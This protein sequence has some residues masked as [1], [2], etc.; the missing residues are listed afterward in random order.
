MRAS[1]ILVRA[2]IEGAELVGVDPAA[3]RREAGLNEGLNDPYAWLPGER[4]D[5]LLCAAVRLSQRPD[6]GLN[7]GAYS[8]MHKLEMLPLWVSN[9]PALRDG[10]RAVERVHQLLFD[11]LPFLFEEQGAECVWTIDAGEL[12]PPAARVVRDSH[13]VGVMRLLRH[14]EVGRAY[15]PIRACFEHDDGGYRA[16][17]GRHFEELAFSQPR[18]ELRF[19]ALEL[20]RTHDNY[21]QE[22][23]GLLQRQI[24]A[25]RVRM[26]ASLPYSDRLKNQLRET[27]P[28]IPDMGEVARALEMSERSLRRRLAD[29]GTTYSQLIEQCQAELAAELLGR[30]GVSVKE[31]AFELGFDT[32]SG[33]YRAFRRWTGR[34]PAK[35][36]DRPSS[37]EAEVFGE[38]ALDVAL[39]EGGD[40]EG[41]V[42]DDPGRDE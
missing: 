38:D 40:G 12:S 16:A 28:R 39:G 27:L 1:T 34:S 3:L 21:N 25:L 13:M 23:R 35:H 37:L 24:E 10:I 19:E 6:F 18:T 26:E 30:P 32:V 14:Y 29:E 20:G 4:V 9:M 8:P 7:W 22:L 2:V 11:G 17:Y 41:G 5:A 15:K 42:G 33:F 31:V 36:R